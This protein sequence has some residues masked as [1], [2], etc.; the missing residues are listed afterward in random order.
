MTDGF[1]RQ[2]ARRSAAL[3]HRAT[4][5]GWKV[6][7]GAP[8]SMRRM[9]IDAP[10]VGYLTDETVVAPGTTVDVSSWQRGIVEFETAVYLDADVSAEAT[11]EEAAAAV[12]SLGPAIELADIDLPMEPT[13]LSDILDANV[14]H[15]HVI[16]GATD[17]ARAG[18]NIDGLAMSIEVDGAEHALVSQLEQLTG[19]YAG[20]V[21]TVANTLAAH[22]VALRAGDVII[23]GTV[24]PPMPVGESTT[25]SLTMTGFD[26][27]SVNVT[28]GG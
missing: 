10:L 19:S 26:T 3:R 16:F 8:A 23:T 5:I 6:G 17:T 2:L 15:R 22:D 12:G 18:L 20:I 24:V 7:F 21:A 13:G 1:A 9:E 25:Y 27:I 11:P 28:G 4:P 14:F